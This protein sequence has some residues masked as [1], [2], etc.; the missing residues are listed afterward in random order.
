MD[1]ISF[2]CARL[3]PNLPGKEFVDDGCGLP[4]SLDALYLGGCQRPLLVP[5]QYFAYLCY[6]LDLCSS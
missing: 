4:I 2:W 3:S 5:E 6:L 1:C